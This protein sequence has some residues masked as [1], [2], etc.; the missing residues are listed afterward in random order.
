MFFPV[1]QE[2]K[3]QSIRIWKAKP[4]RSVIVRRACLLYTSAP[5]STAAAENAPAEES[6]AADN[7]G[8]EQVTLR[9]AWWG[10]QQRHDAT[11]AVIK[12]YEE[13]NPNVKIEAE[14]YD[15]DGY[16]NKLNTLV[17]AN[18][19]WDIFQLGGNFP[20][21]LEKIVPIDPYIEDGTCLLY[22]SNK[23]LT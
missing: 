6:K 5:A 13:Q 14:F 22:T 7:T 4:G 15:M 1:F 11:Q 2:Q 18:D 10:S 23:A 19:V 12:M 3:E 16:L 9:M 20:T 17:A 21:Y 8:G